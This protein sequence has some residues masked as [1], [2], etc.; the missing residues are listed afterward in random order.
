MLVWLAEYLTQYYSGFNVF[1]YVTLRAILSVLTALLIA[2]SV[3]PELIQWLASYKVGQTIRDDGPKSHFSKTGTPTMGGVLIILAISISTLLWTDLSNPY[4]WIILLT[5]WS[6]AAI[7]FY[8]DYQ[9]LVKKNTRGLPARWKYFWQSMAAIVIAISL[10]LCAQNDSYTELLIP[11][12][13]DTFIPLGPF[14][15]LFAYLVI[16]GSSNAVN[17]TDGLDGL[18]ITLTVLVGGALGIF[19]Y[20]TSHIYFADYLF[21][22]FIVEASEM[23]IFAAALV[24]AGLGFLWFNAYPAQVFMGDVGSLALGAVLGVLAIMVRQEIIL[25]I[26]GGIFVVE[27]LSVVLQVFFYKMTK[28]RIFRMAPIHHHFELK[29]WPEP[30]VAVRFMIITVMLVLLGLAS[31]KLR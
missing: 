16:V 9:K 12:L 1:H 26:M 3:G 11:F 2:L 23:T 14:Y 28:K 29:G 21:I 20:V 25:F 13:K 18:A 5:L 10:Y 31:L 8:D 27:T 6:F 30:K 24:G 17:L 7:G 15:I 4:V 22:P 19:A